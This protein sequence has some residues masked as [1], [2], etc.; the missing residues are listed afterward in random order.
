MPSL[1]GATEWL[2]SEPL[3]PAELR[4]VANRWV[5]SAN[6]AL[7]RLLSRAEEEPSGRSIDAGC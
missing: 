2:N 1:G 5:V 4:E 6:R 7:Q 3:G